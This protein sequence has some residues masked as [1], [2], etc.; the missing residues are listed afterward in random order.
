MGS[1]GGEAGGVRGVAELGFAGC[2]E[3]FA[4][5][6]SFCLGSERFRN[7]DIGL[8]RGRRAWA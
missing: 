4:F 8:L 1:E 3:N 5:D 2:F 7:L 6:D